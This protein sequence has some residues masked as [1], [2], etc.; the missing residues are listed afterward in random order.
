MA[1]AGTPALSLRAGADDKRA[2]RHLREGMA[3]LPPVRPRGGFR[4]PRQRQLDLGPP[5]I[6]VEPASR[7]RGRPR[8]RAAGVRDPSPAG[9]RPDER[10]LDGRRMAGRGDASWHN[11]I[12]HAVANWQGEP[13]APP[14][15]TDEPDRPP[16]VPHDT[17]WSQTPKVGASNW[18]SKFGGQEWRF[19]DKGIDLRA[20]PTTSSSDARRAD[21]RAGDP[22]SLRSGDFKRPPR[23]TALRPN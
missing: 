18:H 15:A 5:A 1:L 3:V 12:A 16:I 21:H 7:V 13:A 4:R 10:R 17:G 11:N 20:H 6:D 22:R 2:H 14:I 23:I 8:P 9:H 19:D